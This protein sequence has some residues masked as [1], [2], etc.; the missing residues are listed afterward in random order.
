MTE[1]PH[2]LSDAIGTPRCPH[3]KRPTQFVMFTGWTCIVHGI[4]QRIPA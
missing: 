2:T 4:V 1:Q 3:C